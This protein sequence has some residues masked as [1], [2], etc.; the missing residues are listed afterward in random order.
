[1]TYKKTVLMDNLILSQRILPVLR[2][3][4]FKSALDYVLLL[5]VLGLKRSF[6]HQNAAA[7]DLKWFGMPM[8]KSILTYSSQ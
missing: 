3:S 8:V 7:L 4:G 1:M 5:Q 6:N 2:G